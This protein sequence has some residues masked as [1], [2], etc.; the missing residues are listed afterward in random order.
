MNAPASTPAPP[1]L[2]MSG[3]SVGAMRDPEAIVVEAVNWSVAPG[4]FWVVGG[5]QGAG[6]SDFLFLAGGLM[7]PAGG[8]YRLL[9]EEMPIFEEERLPARL[10]LGLVF[11]GGQLFNQLTLAEN[12]ALPLRYHRNLSPAGAAAEVR[13]MLELTELIPWADST[14][15]AVA[16]NWRQ[17]AGLARA[18]MLRPEVL[19]LDNPL[20]GLDL[21]H[22][23][24]W[25]SLLGR[26]SR[27]HAWMDGRPMTLIATADDLRP[28]RGW[29]RRFAVLHHRRFTVQ[30][31]WEQ[32]EA[33]NDESVR[34]LLNAPEPGG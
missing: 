24:W 34:E 10:R 5:L 16:L 31:T 27:G 18:L 29:A 12:I 23:G 8:V 30:G 17:R 25:L 9:G 1:V 7:R 22:R 4:D 13:R 28:W 21:R 33:A 3:V 32:L 19:L 14:P 15:G 20:A 11:E 2:E 26:L 6:K